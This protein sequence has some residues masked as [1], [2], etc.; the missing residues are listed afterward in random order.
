LIK[1]EDPTI[2]Y[3]QE[4]H[5]PHRK[6]RYLRVKV[7][8]IYQAKVL[9]KQAEVLISDKVDYIPKLVRR[10]KECHFILIK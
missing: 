9:G 1:K 10:D 5:F 4:T 8:K 3:L 2:Y 7:K 6:K